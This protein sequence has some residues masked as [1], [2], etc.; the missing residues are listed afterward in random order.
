MIPSSVVCLISAE[1]TFPKVH[2]SVCVAPLTIACTT[3]HIEW[4]SYEESKTMFGT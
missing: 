3:P 1:L 2:R 4:I